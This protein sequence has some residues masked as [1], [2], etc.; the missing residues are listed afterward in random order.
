AARG[1]DDQAERERVLPQF[2]ERTNQ[3]TPR[4][5]FP[6]SA[7]LSLRPRRGTIVAR[8]PY[9]QCADIASSFPAAAFRTALADAPH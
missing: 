9:R 6:H 5:P 2:Y 4:D 8:R 7:V 1:A 3:S